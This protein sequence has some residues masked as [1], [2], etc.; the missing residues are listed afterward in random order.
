MLSVAKIVNKFMIKKELKENEIEG[1]CMYRK[2]WMEIDLDAIEENVRT[3]HKIC[4]K[5]FIAVVKADAYG[6]GDLEVGNACVRAGASMLAVSSLDEAICLRE[7]GYQGELFVLGATCVEDVDALIAYKV[8]TAGYSMEWVDAVC[9]KGCAGLKVHLKVDTGMNRIG[10]HDLEEMKLAL[11]RLVDAGCLVEGIFTHFCC[12]S[13][14]ME[15]TNKQYARFE[16]AV[17]YLEYPFDWIHCDNSDATIFFKDPISNACRTGISLY[18]ISNYKDDLL[19]PLSMYT[20]ITMVK[21]VNKGDVIGYGATYTAM[22]E[23]WIATLPIG[24]ADGLNRKN[25]GRFVYIDGMLCP[26]VGNVCMD[27]CMVKLPKYVEVG[28]KVEIFGKHISINDMAKELDTIPYEI[29]CLITP[30]VTRV[31]VQGG[32]RYEHNMRLEHAKNKAC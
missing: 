10:F 3:I 1:E 18:G 30:R 4:K 8:A 2:T 27:Q 17:K 26:I 25:Q 14:S 20:R 16:E 12:A 29:M 11:H 24:Y 21:K 9:K 32:N 13:N 15:M 19:E 6:A 5:R 28:T 22:D 7:K 31:Y 23:E